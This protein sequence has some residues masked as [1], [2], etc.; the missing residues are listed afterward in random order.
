MRTALVP[1]VQPSGPKTAKSAQPKWKRKAT[2]AS[3]RVRMRV[4]AGRGG[5]PS[6]RTQSRSLAAAAA[7]RRCHRPQ[8]CQVY[9][10]SGARSGGEGFEGDDGERA[11]C[12]GIRSA[13]LRLRS[14]SSIVWCQ[15]RSNSGAKMASRGLLA[16]CT[17]PAPPME[18]VKTALLD[19]PRDARRFRSTAHCLGK[20][21]FTVG[22][23]VRRSRIQAHLRA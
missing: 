16:A 19:D 8:V 2:V 11:K 5:A 12:V 14:S 23:Q 21:F 3:T 6:R 17:R 10:L 1:V 7:L 13:S 4:G 18:R 15:P 22:S 20:F 9:G